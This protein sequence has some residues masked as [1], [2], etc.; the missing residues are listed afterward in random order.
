MER[1]ALI[2][3]VNTFGALVLQTVVTAVVVDSRGLGLDIVPQVRTTTGALA[4]GSC[5]G[6]GASWGQ[7]PVR[8]YWV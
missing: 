2:F 8:L 4:A 6:S 1:Y 5:R 3:G 7:I